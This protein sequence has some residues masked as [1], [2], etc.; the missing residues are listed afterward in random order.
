MTW[1]DLVLKQHE[2]LESPLSFWRWSALAAISAVVKDQVY[3]DQQLYKLYPNIYVMLHARSGLKKGPPVN[4]AK[5]LVGMVNNTRIITGRASIQAILQ[6]LGTGYTKPDGSVINKAVAFICSSELTSSIVEDKV[7]TDILMDLYDRSYNEGDWKSLLKSGNAKLIDP[8]ITML[9]ATNESHSDEFF[10]KKDIQGGYYAR[11]FIIYENKRNKI[12]SLIKPLINPPDLNKLVI[13]LKE[14]AKLKG[15][16]KKLDE[17]PAGEYYHDWYGKLAIRQ[18]EMDDETGTLNRFGD[19]VLKVAMLL[20]L[21]KAPNLEICLDSMQEAIDQCEKL[22]GNTRRISMGR[23]G[24]S[25]Y[26]TQKVMILKKFLE[27]ENHQISRAQLL[28]DMGYHLNYNELDEIMEGFDQSGT[29][30]KEVHGSS[31]VYIMTDKYVNELSEFF[32]GRNSKK[33]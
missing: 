23:G 11:T 15:P 31:I 24:K 29:V 17:T 22:L 3:L 9:T 19:S 21:A 10:G 30:S 20:S 13:Y 18:D 28:K 12:N 33:S 14:L 7:A 25:Q 27:R 26:A 16:F 2:E 4:F 5:K 8:T 6:E 1:L 32:K